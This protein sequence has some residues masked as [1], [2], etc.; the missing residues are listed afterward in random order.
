MEQHPRRR[1]P[2][3]G[4]S[5]HQGSIPAPMLPAVLARHAEQGKQ[6]PGTTPVTP[7]P[8]PRNTSGAALSPGRIPNSIVN[9]DLLSMLPIDNN[10]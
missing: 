2:G 6:A 5:G 9:D 4:H 1:Q 7:I 8:K 3:T 10:L